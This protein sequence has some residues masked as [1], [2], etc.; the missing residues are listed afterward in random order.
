M[1]LATHRIRRQRWLCG[2]G[3]PA[4]AFALRGL[5]REAQEVAVPAAFERA[6]DAAVRDDEV[7][8]LPRLELRIRLASVDD[9]A[10]ALPEL[11]ARAVSD[12]LGRLLAPAARSQASIPVAGE[13]S[14]AA[15][16]RR[17]GRESR[18]AGL[19]EYLDT[20]TLPW[21]L[22]QAEISTLLAQ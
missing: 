18:L 10:T 5:L 3:S 21:E 12:E 20:G 2:A 19:I 16:A 22:A 15:G 7:V 11:L 14:A 6:F 13:K 17:S 4:A 1:A 8:R 9:V